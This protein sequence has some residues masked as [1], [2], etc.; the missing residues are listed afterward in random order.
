MF[1]PYAVPNMERTGNT[2]LNGVIGFVIGY[3]VASKFGE[4]DALKPALLSAAITA[5]IAWLAYDRVEEL[6]ALDALEDLDAE[7][8]AE[9]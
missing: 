1:R 4:G 6:E 3:V 2:L 5:A 9:A 8:A 7:T